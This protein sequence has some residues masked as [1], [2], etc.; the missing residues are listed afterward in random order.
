MLSY[1]HIACGCAAALVVVAPTTP[2]GCAAVVAAAAVGSTIPD[3]DARKSPDKRD[4]RFGIALALVIAVAVAIANPEVVST[5]AET[6]HAGHVARAALGAVAFVGLTVA[7]VATEHRTFTHSLAALALFTLAVAAVNPELAVPF[8]I[9][10]ATH[11]ALDLLNKR[12]LMLL[13]PHPHRMCLA[14]TRSNAVAN[15]L[16]LAAGVV[17]TAGYFVSQIPSFL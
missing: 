12:G 16:L 11:L 7:G 9:G 17:V 1:T 13:W 2:V 15:A 8:A 6:I 14:L 5:V 3:V 4:A 10:Y